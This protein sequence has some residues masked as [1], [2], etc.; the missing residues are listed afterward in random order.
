[1]FN[2]SD[3]EAPSQT[4]RQIARSF[5]WLGWI[6]FGLQCALGFIP[7]LVVVANV[8]FQPGRQQT[9]RLSLGLWMAIACLFILLFSI[10][11]CFRYTLL[12][13]KLEDRDLRPAKSEV[14]RDLR[15]GIVVNVA[16]MSIALLIALFRVGELTIRML[17]LPQGATVVTPNQVGTTVGSAGTLITP[18]NMI[19][20]Q[21]MVNTIA[22]GLIGLVVT[23]L[24]LYQVRQ[25]RSSYID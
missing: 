25:H 12:A 18:S 22:A 24:L 21:A 4:P 17:T 23:M 15:I 9:G 5:R 2:F 1:M 3:S 16:S 20:I 8:L 6:G 7:I 10:Y 11:W 14:I 19:A 13:R